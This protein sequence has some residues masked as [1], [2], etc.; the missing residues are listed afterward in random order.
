VVFLLLKFAIKEFQEDREFRQ[1]SNATLTNYMGCL[2]EFHTYC[3]EKEIIEVTDITSNTIKS[4]LIYCQRERGNNPTT[5]NSKLRSIKI[6]FNYLQ[7]IEIFNEKNNPIHKVN[8]IKA[9]VKI[10]VFSD[11]QINEM[12]SYYRR[13]KTRDKSLYAYRDS[14]I[15]ITLLGTGMR[16]GELCNLKWTDIDFENQHIIL[17]GK[18]KTQT[19]I[20]MADKLKSEIQEY[21]LFCQKQFGKLPM[22]VF[23]DRTGKQ[24]TPN[25]VKNMFKRL[26]QIINFPNVRCCAYDFRHTFAH[27]FLM[28]GG[29]V[30]TLQKLLRH[31]SPAMTER[32]LAI[33][34]TALQERANQFNPL[35][36][37]NL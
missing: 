11:E 28:N 7:E 22:F 25:A 14:T 34:G 15:I 16:L 6:F 35:N 29:D 5:I 17:F 9:N 33:W 27:R 18:L 37:F 10:E 8:Y 26:K 19:S 1:I 13:F 2:K 30:F 31:S 24:L 32:Y 21:K 3:L 23:V 36:K 20:P 12:L 4:Y